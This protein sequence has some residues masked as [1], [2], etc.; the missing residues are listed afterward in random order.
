MT[1]TLDAPDQTGL[2]PYAAR[3][4]VTTFLTIVLTLGLAG[5]GIS[6]ALG[7]PLEPAI[8]LTAYIGR[9]GGA[10]VVTRWADGPAAARDLLRRVL[11]WRF[12]FGRWLTVLFALPALTIGVAAATGTL[13]SP[14]LGWVAETGLY[15]FATL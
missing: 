4:P 5:L 2:R 1:T 12:G 11:R 13:I 8:L 14:P 3:R 6:A 15:L 7:A 9:A 10:L